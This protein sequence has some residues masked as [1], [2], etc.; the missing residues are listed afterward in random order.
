MFV[1]FVNSSYYHPT[2]YYSMCLSNAVAFANV[3]GAL[4][5]AETV[6]SNGYDSRVNNCL[7]KAMTIQ[8]AYNK[9]TLDSLPGYNEAAPNVYFNNLRIVGWLDSY[10]SIP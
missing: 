3:I 4:N 1:V 10:N 7:T 5:L 8:S 9:T 2:N 6:A